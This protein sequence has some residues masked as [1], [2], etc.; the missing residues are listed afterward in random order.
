MVD[1]KDIQPFIYD[2]GTGMVKDG[3][4]VSYIV[5]IYEGCALPHG[6]LRLDLT[7]R[8]MIDAWMKILTERGYSFTT[9]T[10]REI[11]RDMKENLAYVALD[12]EQEMETVGMEVIGIHETT[13]N[14][15]LKCDIRKD[16][17]GYIVLSGGSTMF[18]GIVDRMSKEITTL[19]PSNMKIEVVAPLE[20]MYNV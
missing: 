6:I 10:E 1:T 3:D 18:L 7:G 2:N 8:D 13:Y 20:M 5:L 19:A 11:I 17:N 12:Y 14:S 4:G 16:L 15:I 9:T